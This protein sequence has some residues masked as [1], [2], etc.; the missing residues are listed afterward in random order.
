MQ[1]GLISS[2]WRK[3]ITMSR[4]LYCK[5]QGVPFTLRLYSRGHHSLEYSLRVVLRGCF[6]ISYCHWVSV[7]RHLTILSGNFQGHFFPMKKGLWLYIY[8]HIHIFIIYIYLISCNHFATI[9]FFSLSFFF[10]KERTEW[11]FCRRQRSSLRCMVSLAKKINHYKCTNNTYL[12]SS[13][14]NYSCT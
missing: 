1:T 14:L 4:P 5:C 7:L 6:E 11:F 2:K 10:W 13:F 8:T 9:L 12:Y 3:F